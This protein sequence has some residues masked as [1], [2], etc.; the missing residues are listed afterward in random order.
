MTEQILSSGNALNLKRLIWMRL[1]IMTAEGIA[2]W[3]AVSQWHLDLSMTALTGI[4][5]VMGIISILTFIRLHFD[6]PVSDIELFIQL[7]ME[8]LALTA[9]LYFSGGSTN[10]F[11]PFY[12][13]PLTLT[14]A[15]LSG[16]YTW[17]M[18]LFTLACYTLLL[19]FNV[20]LPA[21]HGGHGT[22]FRLHE[23]GMWFGFLLSAVLIA[24]FAVR[25]AS[26]VRNR[27]RMIADMREQQLRQERVLALGTLAAGAA[28]ELGTPLATMAVV[29][30]DLEPEQAISGKKLGILRAQVD[31]CKHILGSISA[32][33]GEL[34]AESGSAQALDTYLQDLL[35]RWTAS[36][37]GIQLQQ[38][39]EGCKPAPRVVIDQTLE[40][41]LINILNNAADASPMDVKVDAKWTQHE[42][43]ID[44]A[45]RG[46]GISTELVNLAGNTIL[47]TKQDGLGLGLFLSYTTLQRLGGD[48]QLVNRKDGGVICRIR[49]QI[50]K[51]RV[52]ENDQ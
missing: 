44:V 26:T 20:P 42:L 49:L 30:K 39:L 31:R 7:L 25:M 18:M 41:A 35:Q 43:D 19:F 6:W 45:D 52:S 37:N 32:A 34:R 17:A 47:S 23:M 13:L 10:P 14:A 21:V 29:L 1:I 36:R 22:D 3:V 9:V 24:A 46:E 12:L 33:A 40:Q 8:V 38:H 11:A 5:V 51:L 48:V 4:W 16:I 50:D 2:A 15:S 28:H 27:E